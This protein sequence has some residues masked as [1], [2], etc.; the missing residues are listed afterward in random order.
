M[1]IT[2]Q[3]ITNTT[4]R[5]VNRSK[6]TMANAENELSTEKKITR[7]SDDPIVAI[8]ALSLR[9]SLA[10]IDMYLNTNIPAASAWMQ[11]TEGALDNMDAILQDVYKYCTQGASDEFTEDDRSAIIQVLEQYKDALYAETNTDYAGRYCFSGY[12]TESSFTF[13]DSEEASS[14]TYSITQ[15]FSSDDLVKM[16]VMTNSVDTETIASI[17]AADRPESVSVYSLRLAYDECADADYS[18]VTIDGT[19]YSTTAVS[20]ADFQDMVAS[21]TFENSSNQFYYIYDTGNLAMS[22]DMY[23]T[24]QDAEEI[25]FTYKKE[26]FEKGEVRPEMYFNCSD[27]TDPADPIDYTKAEDGQIISYAI[28]FGQSL[29]VN[30]LGC[31]T[32]SYNIARDIDDMC[33]ALQNVQDI[34]TKISKLTEMSE[35]DLYTDSEKE[36]IASMLEA[37]NQ[38]LD[39]AKETMENLFSTEMSRV[40]GYQQTVDLQLADLGS[41]D[42]RLTLTKSRLTSQYTTFEDLKSQNEDVELEETVIEFSSAQTLYQAAL[43]AAS[44]CVQQSLLDYI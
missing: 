20:Y 40:K 17:S 16:D 34:E 18:T 31:E 12:R 10:E 39:Y 21:G 14:K 33:N 26:G 3:M 22:N 19:S 29:Q 42:T 36:D 8:K 9:S 27:I 4:M 32:L 13:L 35:S 30:T 2:N 11:V 37:A 38:E 15:D 43:S 6:T 25:S 44:K 1:R 7:P 28:N 41:R 24:V 23:D 5:N